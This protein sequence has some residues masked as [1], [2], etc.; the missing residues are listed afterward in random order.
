MSLFPVEECPIETSWP[1]AKQIL[2]ILLEDLPDFMCSKSHTLT[3]VRANMGDVIWKQA[4]CHAARS[5]KRSSMCSTAKTSQA[6]SL[7]SVQ[8]HMCRVILNFSD[9]IRYMI[10][11]DPQKI[12]YRFLLLEMSARI[13]HLKDLLY[14][15]QPC[16]IEIT[17]S[18][19]RV[20]ILSHL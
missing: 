18:F 6:L 16:H 1:F 13:S 19:R 14:L 20:T 10:K 7:N 4:L 12:T 9:S 5:V 11:K 15:K 2:E 3:E 8:D 17:M